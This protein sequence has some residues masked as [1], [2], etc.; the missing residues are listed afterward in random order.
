MTRWEL[1]VCSP[2][3][4]IVRVLQKLNIYSFVTMYQ[5]LVSILIAINPIHNLQIYFLLGKLYVIELQFLLDRIKLFYLC[6]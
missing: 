2:S 3:Q 1:I 4:E 6:C 5:P